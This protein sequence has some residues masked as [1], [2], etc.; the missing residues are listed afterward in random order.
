M[1]TIKLIFSILGVTL[2][3]LSNGQLEPQ[4]GATEEPDLDIGKSI[5]YSTDVLYY[6]AEYN[7]DFGKTFHWVSHIPEKKLKAVSSKDNKTT[8][9]RRTYFA[10]EFEV[11]H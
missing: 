2:A 9:V 1:K 10:K 6:I 8:G 11:I 3:T 5:D 7:P 4:H